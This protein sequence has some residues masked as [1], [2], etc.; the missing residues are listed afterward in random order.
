MEGQLVSHYRILEK[1]GGGGMGVVY[2]AQDERLKRLVALKFLPPELTRDDEARQRF[3]QEAQAASALD[4]P[5]ICTIHEIDTT[6]DGRMFLAMAFY[7]GET[8]KRQIDRG[9]MPFDAALDIAMQVALGLGNAHEAGIVHRDIK[10][11]NL[12]MTKDGIVKIVDF[13]IAKLSG[14]TGLTRTGTSLG[15]VAYMAPEQLRGGNVDKRADLWALGVVLY[16][17]LTGRLPFRADHDVAVVSAILNDEPPSVADARPDTPPTLQQIVARLLQKDPAARYGS[18]LDLRRDLAECRERLTAPQA[19]LA[20]ASPWLV[21]RRPRVAVPVVV[22]LLAIAAG[23]TW[24][25]SRGAEAR[26]ARGEALPEVSRLIEEGRLADAFERARAVERIIP[27]DPALTELWPQ[28]SREVSFETT[29]PGADISFREYSEVDGAWTSLGRSPVKGARFPQGTFRFQFRAPGYD[30]VETM[31]QIGGGAPMTV[32][33]VLREEGSVPAGMVAVDGGPLDLGFVVLRGAFEPVKAPAY[34]I[35]RSEVTNEAYR[36]FVTGGGYQSKQYWTHAFT[37]GGRPVSWETTMSEFKDAT[38]RTGPATWTVGT[39]P[40]G[41]AQLPVTGVSWYEAAAYC[42]FAGKSLPTIYHWGQAASVDA[43]QFI[44]PIS[45]FGTSGPVAADDARSVSRSGTYNMAGNA[46][47]WVWNASADDRYIVGGAWGDPEYK[48]FEPETRS[49]LD[50]AS[51]NGFR[52]AKYDDGEPIPSALTRSMPLPGRDYA[53][54]QAASDEVFEAYKSQYLYD[55]A[56]LNAVVESVD[57]TAEHWR[58]EK[59]TFNAAYGNERMSADLYLPKTSTPPYQTVVYF[60]G[61][62]G[63]FARTSSAT[64]PDVLSFLPTSGRA[65]MFP[66]YDGTYERN[67]GDLVSGYARDDRLYR[68]YAIRWVQ[69]FM[70]SVDYLETRSEIDST[71][72]AYMGVSWGAQPGPI[73]STV[74]PRVAVAVLALAGLPMQRALPEVDPINFVRHVRVPVLMLG[75]QFDY[76]YPLEASQRP[77]FNL[78]GTPAADKRHVVFPGVGHELGRVRNDVI[79]EVLPWLDKYLGPVK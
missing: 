20:G 44:V 57:D 38:G 31:A 29:P 1:L 35:D 45:N 63:F 17:L 56:E 73:V 55:K 36:A 62:G 65:V 39:F 2:K 70:R 40:E 8:L 3:M 19:T 28:V 47:E 72:L 79:R 21:L 50:R 68:D 32:R 33:R 41:Q 42:E 53:R 54:E 30:T 60:P 5:N 59:V 52:C 4:H 67:R 16:Q 9:P 64:L 77:M 78:L 14:A 15:T 49:P 27:G 74:E 26:W 69:D 18:A 23:G 46:R 76:V 22:A 13:G 61:A 12:M 58:R 48:F 7:E 24:A 71:N 6:A 34:F 25:W 11:A 43:A 10:P 51:T 37:K 75:G 66:V